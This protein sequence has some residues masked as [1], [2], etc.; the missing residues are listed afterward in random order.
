MLALVVKNDA[1][2][3]GAW[4]ELVVEDP[5]G[6]RVRVVSNGSFS[7]E[8]SGRRNTIFTI[9]IRTSGAT[10]TRAAKFCATVNGIEFGDGC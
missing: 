3:A 7:E 5:S 8:S 1:S 4:L 6:R 9:N 10:K 2:E